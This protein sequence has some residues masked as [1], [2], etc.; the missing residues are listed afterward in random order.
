MDILCFLKIDK[1]FFFLKEDFLKDARMFKLTIVLF[2]YNYD[3]LPLE[4]AFPY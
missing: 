1:G 3:Y 4:E 2:P